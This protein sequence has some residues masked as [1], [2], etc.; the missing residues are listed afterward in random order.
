MSHLVVYWNLVRLN[1]DFRRLYMA[2]LVSFAGDW[3][4][5]V[6]LLGL[7]YESTNSPLAASAVL[8]ALSLPAALL[9]PVTGLV[10]DRV[11]RKVILVVSD[12]LR[13]ILALSLLL[14][15]AVGTVWF[16]LTIVFLEG[17]GAAFFYPA[18]AG[19]LPNVVNER[20]LPAANAL[21]SSAWGTMAALGA[22]AG[23]VFATVVSRDAAFVFNAT[24]FLLSAILVARIAT[25]LQHRR[26]H[27]ADDRRS[28]SR[29]FRYIFSHRRARAL[30]TSKGVHS[31]TSGGAVSLFAL[32]SITLFEAGDAGTGA[33]FGARGL[34]NMVGPI[35][36]L[37]IIGPATHRILGSIGWMMVVWGVAYIFVGIAPTLL[38]AAVA[39]LVAHMGGGSQFT[40]STYGLQDLMPD[41]VRG[42]VF[43]LDFGI[44]M[45]AIS[46]SALVVGALAQTIPIRPLFVGLGIV[47]IAFG[48]I[49]TAVTRS[50]WADLERP[51]VL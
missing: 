31:L 7:V 32:M 36:A 4:L 9:A 42:R 2:R 6:P 8:A 20:D 45:L 10:S 50:Y 3:F 5:V 17:A 12:V 37:A 38:L 21:M 51:I 41:D 15:D 34:G 22:A 16:P 39:V 11:D 40:F 43:A 29:A 13:A 35:L 18:S 25:S 24:S 28:N 44:D 46:V 48:S 23:G 14:T 33:L 30:L 19:A 47:A 27:H 1:P 26:V 49:W